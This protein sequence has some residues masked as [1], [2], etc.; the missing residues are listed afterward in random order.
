VGAKLCITVT[1]RTMAELRKRRDEVTDAD[2]VELR[3]DTV[4]DPSAPAALE[5]R[6]RPVIVTCRA[7]WEGGHFKGAEEERRRLLG[8]AQRLGAEYIDVEWKAGFHELLQARQGRGIVLSMHDFQGVPA[9]LPDRARAMRASGAEVV[10]LAVTARRLSDA[11]VLPPLAKSATGQTV[12]LAMGEAGIPSRVLAAR[13]GSV[14]TYAGDGV[15][16]GQIPASR[17]CQ[18]FGFARASARAAVYGVAGRPV[19]HSLSPAMHNAAFAASGIEA[20][21]V[22]LPA[23]DFSDFLSFADALSIAGV[24][25]T[26]PFKVNAFEHADTDEVGRR[27]G[28]VNTL[29]RCDGR[30]LAINTDVAGFLAPLVERI[31]PAGRR[32]TILGAGGAARAVA[33]ALRSVGAHVSIAARHRD[34]AAG[35]A[36]A[37]DARVTDWP[38]AGSWDILVNA[39]PVGTAPAREESPLPNGPFNGELV[40]DLVYNPPDTRL[41][42]EARAAGCRTIGGLEML[43]AQAERQFAW[44]TGREPARGVMRAAALRALAAALTPETSGT[45]GTLQ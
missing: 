31:Q 43:V 24:S 9:D 38:P 27:V 30:W 25:V 18:D 13:F 11:L 29:R 44:W 41:V 39:T 20:V 28:A 19:M 5:G 17:L 12:L 23:S 3:L 37:T 36:E 4:D 8:E 40:Y 32:V 14:W 26:A 6:S 16:P 35:V 10:K 15:A 33:V 22:P 2:L 34:R 1:G 7:P 42:R 45:S 21:Y